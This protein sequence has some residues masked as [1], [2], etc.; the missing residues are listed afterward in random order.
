M[1]LLAIF[2]SVITTGGSPGSQGYALGSARVP[3]WAPHPPALRLVPLW[4]S[5]NCQCP[6]SPGSGVAP[7]P[8]LFPFCPTSHTSFWRPSLWRSLALDQQLQIPSPGVLCKAAARLPSVAAGS[9]GTAPWWS[10]HGSQRDMSSCSP[11][12][13]PASPP[14]PE[15]LGLSSS[16][17]QRLPSVAKAR[18]P[19]HTPC[20]PC[21]GSP[22]SRPL[23]SFSS[24][25]PAVGS[26]PALAPP[27]VFLALSLLS[28]TEFWSVIL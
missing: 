17:T 18:R 7:H 22:L 25:S 23:V 4:V 21:C 5:P 16:R 14:N 11:S 3:T 28:V 6:L 15:A 26:V 13:L 1:R 24:R 12:V 20:A 19:Q 8:P 27:W 10:S 2:L 9:L